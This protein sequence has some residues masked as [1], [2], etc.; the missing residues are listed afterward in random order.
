MTMEKNLPAGAKTGADRGG[1]HLDVILTGVP[2]SGT[3]LVCALLNRVPSVVALDEPMP[4][5]E[6]ALRMTREMVIHE[7]DHFFVKARNSLMHT[8]M[9]PSRQVDAQVPSNP[10]R[11]QKDD[12]GVRHAHGTLGV[13]ALA[14]DTVL[15]PDFVLVVKHTA[16]FTG[17]LEQLSRKHP[18][19]AV[20]R[21]PIATL[22][23]WATID[24][25]IRNGRTPAAERLDPRL[26]AALAKIDSVLDRQIH[27][28]EWYLERFRCLPEYRVIRYDAIVSSGGRSL[29]VI[30]PAATSLA[31]PLSRKNDNPLYDQEHMIQIGRRL[32]VRSGV[33]WDFYDRV[34]TERV[35]AALTDRS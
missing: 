34:A 35:L 29:N 19:F 20:I 22:A 26:A 21:E 15:S 18:C 10:F 25:P 27:I 11:D 14:P 28:L 4:L 16:G 13:L 31:E 24:A 7:I 12:S 8:G 17:L 9:A 1:R 6:W 3:T 33:L 2:R 5:P 23:S 32:I 30:A